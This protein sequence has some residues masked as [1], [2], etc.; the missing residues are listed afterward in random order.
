MLRRFFIAKP[1]PP[2]TPVI[3]HMFVSNTHM[4]QQPP[5]SPC[6]SA[7]R[8]VFLLFPL[9][10]ESVNERSKRRIN[11]TLPPPFPPHPTRWLLA[12]FDEL[13]GCFERSALKE[14]RDLVRLGT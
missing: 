8:L 10:H 7:T 11:H 2:L 13:S 4:L 14:W 3:L 12:T 5:H 9:D 6:S 1:F